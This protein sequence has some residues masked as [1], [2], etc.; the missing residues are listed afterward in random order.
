[1]T[2][3]NKLTL[4][5]LAVIPVIE[6]LLLAQQTWC[7]HLSG[8]LFVLAAVT[9]LLDGKIARKTNTVTD[10]GKVFDPVADKLLTL[11]VLMPLTAWGRIPWLASV[12]ILGREL[13]I[14]GYRTVFAGRGRV[15]AAGPWGK[16]KTTIT[17]IAL[18]MLL[19]EGSLPFL[20]AWYIS[21]IVLWAAVILTVISLVDYLVRN[22]MDRKEI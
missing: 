9:D 2:L 1:M 4:G 3:A 19:F 11:A 15:I 6:G 8:V 16:W 7:L 18:V 5:R 21:D 12:I 20:K 10:F 22:P 13:L 14:G 17:D